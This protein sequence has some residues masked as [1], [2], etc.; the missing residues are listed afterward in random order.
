MVPMRALLFLFLSCVLLCRGEDLP[1]I[2]F[3]LA[4]DQSFDSLGCYGNPAVKTP[5]IDAL[6]RD[7]LVFDHYYNTTAICMASRAT[8]FTGLYEYRTGCNF[9]KGDLPARLFDQSYPALLREAGYVTAMAGKIGIE[10]EGVGL[11]EDRFDWWGAGPGQTSYRTAA[12][13]SMRRYADRYPHS[14][15]SYGAFGADFVAWAVGQGRPFCLSIS[16]KAPHRPVSPDP[17]FDGIY[18]GTIFRQP[19][20]FGREHG[21]HLPEQSRRGRQYPRF[22]TWGYRDRYQETLAKYHQLNHAI[23]VAVGM[24][25]DAVDDA[26]A[27]DRT[28]FFFTSDNG[29]LNGAHGY[30]SKVLPYEESIRAPLIVADPRQAASHGKRTSALSGNVDIAPTVLDLAGI[31]APEGLDGESLLGVL[32][33][34]GSEHHDYLALMNCWGPEPVQFLGLVGRR[35]KYVYWYFDGEEMDPAEELYDLENDRLELR[36]LI[37]VEPA[38]LE[39]MRTRYDEEVEQIGERAGRE[40]YRV[41]ATLFNRAVSWPEK[42]KLLPEKLTPAGR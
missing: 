9:G 20:N 11:P 30:G 36:N 10:V 37:E 3:F 31:P 24:V 25:R 12:N 22:V 16:F 13:P 40:N 29:Y 4:D 42:R 41:Y 6:A 14:T 28:V 5:R 1:N 33:D 32:A 38:V 35:Y 21:L 17:K 2:V 18:D 7:G 15:L 8:L 26:G 39:R 27:A 34:P 19:G 23:D